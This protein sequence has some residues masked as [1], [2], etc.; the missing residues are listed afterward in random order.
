[1]L[2]QGKVRRYLPNSE[3]IAANVI[4]VMLDYKNVVDTVNQLPLLTSEVWDS[5][6]DPLSPHLMY[7][8]VKWQSEVDSPQRNQ[9]AGRP[10]QALQ[11]AA[12][13]WQHWLGAGW[14]A[15]LS[16]ERQIEY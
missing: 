10:S 11:Q 2:R 5:F 15:D 9:Q 7:Y 3:V 6:S 14:G 8:Q 4:K 16:L 1:M 13:L 12:D